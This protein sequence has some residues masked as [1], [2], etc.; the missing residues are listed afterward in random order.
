M[1]HTLSFTKDY[2]V[3]DFMP[4]QVTE[5]NFIQY[6][7]QPDYLKNNQKY[8]TNPKGCCK[9]L[10]IKSNYIDIILDGGNIIKC[11]N[12]IIMTDKVFVENSNYSK[13]ELTNQLENTFI[14]S[15][16]KSLRN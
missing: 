15:C 4:I 16:R 6:K 3:R 13:L 9:S 12:Q 10:K 2:W 7:Y 14:T 5:N 11:S 1:I 8:I